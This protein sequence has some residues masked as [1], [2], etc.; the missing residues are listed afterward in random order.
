MI[1]I[2]AEIQGEDFFYG[3]TRPLLENFVKPLREAKDPPLE[4]LK[5]LSIEIEITEDLDVSSI[6]RK[7]SDALDVAEDMGIVSLEDMIFEDL[8]DQ[9]LEEM[10]NR[11]S[12]CQ[13]GSEEV[14][15]YKEKS[16]AKLKSWGVYKMMKKVIDAIET[17]LKEKS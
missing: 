5:R 3:Y 6:S 2:A 8:T 9:S 10:R 1:K 11:K 12:I 7:A 13:D 16:A 14:R 17:Y 15:L 4:L